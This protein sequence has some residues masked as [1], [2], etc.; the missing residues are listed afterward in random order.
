LDGGTVDEVSEHTLQR[1][2]AHCRQSDPAMTAYGFLD[3]INKKSEY[4]YLNFTACKTTA[5]VYAFGAS[6]LHPSE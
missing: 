1:L 3:P 5:C 6:S 4:M 2:R